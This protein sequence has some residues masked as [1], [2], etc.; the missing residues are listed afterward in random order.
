MVLECTPTEVTYVAKVLDVVEAEHDADVFLLFVE[1]VESDDDAH[2]YVSRILDN[3]ETQRQGV[4]ELRAKEGL[5]PWSLLP[6]VCHEPRGA[7]S[8]RLVA[9]LKWLRLQV[10]DPGNHLVFG[11]L[12]VEIHNVA[13]YAGAVQGLLPEDEIEPWMAGCRLI[14]RDDRS[15][16]ALIPHL[17]Q[18]P[19]DWVLLYERLDLSPA[20]LA[21]ALVEQA[22]DRSAPAEE[23]V[24]ALAQLAAM[25]FSHRRYADSFKKW[26]ALFE[27]YSDKDVPAMQ[28]LCLCGAGDVLRAMGKP[29]DA[30]EKYQQ[31]LAYAKEPEHLSVT[32]NLLL[33]AGEVCITLAHWEEAEGYLHLA[34]QI[35]AAKRMLHPQCDLMARRGIPLIALGRL[36]DAHALWRACVDMTRVMQ[37]FPRCIE[38]LERIIHLAK[39]RGLT[40]QVREH[41]AE[42]EEVREEQR[43]GAAA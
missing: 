32:L 27:Y 21:Q 22:E 10:P 2:T 30:K 37:Y 4:N 25:D 1:N 29:E 12:P 38:T 36:D 17:Q 20:A 7:P 14:V 13:A 15:C 43:A 34:E 33:G 3:V 6:P 8:A 23:R 31:G 19:S 28:G 9:M 16:P 40:A 26:G 18:H 42:L 35:A 11:L 39:S 5:E 24:V 41:E